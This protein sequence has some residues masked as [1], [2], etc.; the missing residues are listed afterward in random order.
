MLRLERRRTERSGRPVLLM[1]VEG[2][3]ERRESRGLL[4][5]RVANAISACT[6]E[7]DILGWYKQDLTLGLLMTEITCTDMATI[8]LLTEKISLA[9]QRAV[10][11][12]AFDRLKFV[13]RI[14]PLDASED[15]DSDAILFP[16]LATL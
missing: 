1:L 2:G 13:F 3:R 16:D 7:T 10:G 9:I 14:Y 15:S 4:F 8:A 5:Y 11:P 6:R 12:V